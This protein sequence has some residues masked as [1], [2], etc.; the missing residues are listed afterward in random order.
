[1]TAIFRSTRSS[2]NVSQPI[3]AYR[4]IRA[5]PKELEAS[6]RHVECLVFAPV[7]RAAASVASRTQVKYSVREITKSVAAVRGNDLTL[8]GLPWC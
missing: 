8:G 3:R 2:R 1:M 5:F 6:T 4:R 7:R